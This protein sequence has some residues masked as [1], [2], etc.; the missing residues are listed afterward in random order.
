MKVKQL[1]LLVGAAIALSLVYAAIVMQEGSSTT[2]Q[3]RSL[4]AGI[5]SSRI[6]KLIMVQGNDQVELAS[7]DGQWTVPSRNNYPADA[8][9]VNAFLLKL[10]DLTSSQRI[11]TSAESLKKLG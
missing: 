9:K 7:K 5:S 3:P 10:F 11:P 2:T 4:L 6:A 1:Q 8:S